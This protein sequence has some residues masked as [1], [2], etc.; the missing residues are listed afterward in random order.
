MKKFPIF[1]N[2]MS[3]VLKHKDTVRYELAPSYYGSTLDGYFRINRF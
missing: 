2:L 3:E 1:I